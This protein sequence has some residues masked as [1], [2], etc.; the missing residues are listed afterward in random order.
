MSFRTRLITASAVSQAGNWLT[1]LAGFQ[2]TQQH[3]G[4]AATAMSFLVQSLPAL[5]SAKTLAERVPEDRQFQAWV[6]L[7]IVL[8][9]LTLGLAAVGLSYVAILVYLGVATTLRTISSTLFMAIISSR[10]A[11][12]DREPTFT[13][14]G[15]TGSLTL[16]VAP[17]I[18]GAF[19]AAAGFTWL[20]II[21]ALTFVLAAAILSLP[22]RGVV[23]KA[24]HDEAAQRCPSDARN[25][26][27]IKDV[28]S[29]S[30][31]LR[32][33]LRCWWLFSIAGAGVNA[34]ELPIFNEV[35]HFSISGTG[36]A[37]TAYGAGGT[38]AFIVGVS[39]MRLPISA[40][41]ISL[42][43][44]CALTVWIT[45]GPIGAYAGFFLGGA[46]YG[47]MSGRI[48]MMFDTNARRTGITPV[49]IWGWANRTVLISNVVVYALASG[50]FFM[51]LN[52]FQ[53]AFF[54]VLLAAALSVQLFLV[55]TRDAVA[56]HN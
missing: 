28:L 26:N 24:R 41:A 11:V 36:V 48:R 22:S 30:P 7:Q 46:S 19:A 5:L 29:S 27:N 15:A 51:G 1:F 47:L 39:K 20:L 31:A 23:D 40:G 21:D 6:V 35:Y 55:R 8:S 54:V 14:L 52:G 53:S 2:F 43:Y 38:L 13:A 10:L 12:S 44:T 34:V 56:S 25:P 45:G 37:L 9:G 16:T 4:S 3:F 32:R 17:A 18:G 49:S 42:V 33:S 50:A